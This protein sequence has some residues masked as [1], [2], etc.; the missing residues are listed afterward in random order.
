MM[1]KHF[2]IFTAVFFALVLSACKHHKGIIWLNHHA[3]VVTD[4]D[5]IRLGTNSTV[6]F[7]EPKSG[8]SFPER[9]L[10]PIY[11]SART[12]GYKITGMRVCY[13]IIGDHPDTE[14]HRLRLTQ[15][16]YDAQVGGTVW[17]RYII[18]LEDTNT[19]SL[20]PTPPAGGPP[21]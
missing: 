6:V 13:G 20:A 16:D 17:P 15:F 4:T 14:V 11:I 9:H 8:I 19:G 2:L 7:V 5:R 12:P 1:Q 3:L 18:K 10:L 21:R